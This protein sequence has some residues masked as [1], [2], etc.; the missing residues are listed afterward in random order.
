MMLHHISVKN[1][2]QSNTLIAQAVVAKLK[3]KILKIHA[4]LLYSPHRYFPFQ[5]AR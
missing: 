1:N 3:F 2:F 5:M 4:T